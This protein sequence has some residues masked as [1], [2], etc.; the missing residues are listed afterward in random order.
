M[1][2]LEKISGSENLRQKAEDL[3]HFIQNKTNPQPLECDTLKL[4]HELQVHQIELELQNEELLY[5]KEQAEIATKQYTELYDFA[6]TG[7]F[8]LSKNAQIIKLNLSGAKMLG[9]ERSLLQNSNF[10]FFVTPE[11]KPIFNLFLENVFNSNRVES[12]E[13]I[14]LENNHKSFCIYL[15]GIAKDNKEECFV[16]AMDITDR[17][18]MEL[19]VKHAK[20]Q[21]EESDHL[22]TIFLQNISH[23][24]RTPMNAIMGFSDLLLDNFGN[25][26]KLEEFTQIIKQQS[27]DLLELINEILDLSKIET[28]LM[29]INIEECDLV[30]FLNE[31]HLFFINYRDNI[32]KSHINLQYSI[33][34][35]P[36]QMLVLIDKG[37][38]KQIFVNLVYNAFKF[39]ENGQ[40]IFGCNFDDKNNLQFFVSDTGIGIPDNK[41][42]VIFERFMQLD[43]LNKQIQ[44]GTGLGLSIVKSLVELLDGKIS[45]KSEVG[46]GTNFNFSVSYHIINSIHNRKN[47]TNQKIKV[48]WESYTILI[49][50][51]DSSSTQYLQEVLSDTGITILTAY[52]ANQSIEIVRTCQNIDIILM[53][54]K[55]PDM[56]GFDATD[57]IKRINPNIR[58]I[59][60]TACASNY[61]KQNALK[62]GCDD[63]ISKPINKKN[64]FMKINKQLN[65]KIH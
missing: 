44:T 26:T 2:N 33:D 16:T 52:N 55:M 29:P 41:Q 17:K 28:G 23:E 30:Q 53:D 7:Y 32:G 57:I 6:P 11:T 50:E 45:L 65:H 38:L 8:T 5:A 19:E 49:V 48:N 12:C 4:I 37:K 18:R 56:N 15:T 40:I 58:I 51:D 43:P 1:E 42:A 20:A 62:A 64:L 3:I 47:T 60:Q 14:L 25:K 21:A 22:K 31:L 35:N 10:G 9:K 59:A 34:N 24:I 13:I 27:A 36:N 61:D 63:Y 39:T 46:K 54:I